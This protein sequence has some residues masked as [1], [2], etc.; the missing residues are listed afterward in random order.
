[1]IKRELQQSIFDKYAAQYQEKY[2]ELSLY[3]EMLDLLLSHIQRKNARVLDVGCGPGNISRYLLDRRADL[4]ILGIDISENMLQ[5]ARSN[6]PEAHFRKMDALQM[7]TLDHEFEAITAGFC[8]P[9]LS[10]EESLN[11]IRK[12]AKML[13][14]EGMLYLSL[15]ES[16]HGYSEYVGSTTDPSEQLY[17]FYHEKE[18]L[19][20]FLE[21]NNFRIIAAVKLENKHNKPGVQDLVIVAQKVR[22]IN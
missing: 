11:F 4:D 10:K 14:H 15:M 5:L 17:T 2:M 1:M 12:C 19:L 8:L 20:E 3:A 18:Y 6:N 7:H 13:K 9:Y 22:M 21:E 16:A